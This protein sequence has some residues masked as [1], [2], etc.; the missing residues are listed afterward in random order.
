[1]DPNPNKISSHTEDRSNRN[2]QIAIKFTEHI[3]APKTICLVIVSVI[4]TL[5][6]VC[7]KRKRKIQS[8]QAVKPKPSFQQ[9]SQ[10][11]K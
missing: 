11:L 8:E 2:N 5:K 1:M 3:C 6:L 4:V 9:V 10:S 7:K